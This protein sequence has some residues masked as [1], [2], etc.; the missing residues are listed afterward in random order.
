MSLKLAKKKGRLSLY[1][2]DTELE[3]EVREICE[4]EMI[5]AI[6]V[7]E[8]HARED[9]IKEV[10]NEVIAKYAEQEADEDSEASKTNF[11]QDC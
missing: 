5:K 2:I 7:Q 6:Q 3:A 4:A 1:E 9:A 8:K 11:G 10:K